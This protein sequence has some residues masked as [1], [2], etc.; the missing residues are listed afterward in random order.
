M[1]GKESVTGSEKK[2]VMGIFIGK[3]A[4]EETIALWGVRIPAVIVSLP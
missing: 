3:N 2:G 1:R 4:H